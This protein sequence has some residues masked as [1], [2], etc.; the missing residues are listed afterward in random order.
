MPDACPGNGEQLI[1]TCAGAAYCGQVAN[2]GGVQAM[3]EGLGRLFCLAAMSAR[4]EEKMQRAR[5]AGRRI[6][7]DGCEDDCARRTLELAGLSV[8]AHVRVTDLG[9]EKQ[10]REPH[11][12][13]HTRRVVE[14]VREAVRGPAPMQAGPRKGACGCQ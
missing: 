10:P 4:R 13:I 3:T 6:A 7:I 2:R 11:W 9:I 5:A 14:K 12:L 1:F 8:D